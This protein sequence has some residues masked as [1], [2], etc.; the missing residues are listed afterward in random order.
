MY[1]VHIVHS[2]T[3]HCKILEEYSVQ[4]KEF[5]SIVVRLYI[6]VYFKVAMFNV[7]CRNA[8]FFL[9]HVINILKCP[10][11]LKN[12]RTSGHWHRHHCKTTPPTLWTRPPAL[13]GSP[14]C[15]QTST[16]RPPGFSN[17]A[18]SQHGWLWSGQKVCQ[19]VLCSFLKTQ[20]VSWRCDN[21]CETLQMPCNYMT[22]PKKV[23]DA[24]LATEIWFLLSVRWTLKY[25]SIFWKCHN[26]WHFD[27]PLSSEAQC[28]YELHHCANKVKLV[29]FVYSRAHCGK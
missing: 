11:S 26:L 17:T 19:T 28:F 29:V 24:N 21:F 25:S 4:V 23:M 1:K 15:P 20:T 6:I 8:R 5:N 7:K 16:G 12:F 2:W 10:D 3:A 22:S 18:H 9:T 14:S 27:M 13:C